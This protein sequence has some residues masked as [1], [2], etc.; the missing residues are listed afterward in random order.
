[1]DE[2]E[3]AGARG[4]S[5][6]DRVIRATLAMG[7]KFR[8]RRV[9]PAGDRLLADLC[10]P[11]CRGLMNENNLGEWAWR[12][13]HAQSRPP[14]LCHFPKTPKSGL[15]RPRGDESSYLIRC[16]RIVSRDKQAKS[17]RK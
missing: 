5:R 11:L 17:S 12:G 3:G 4:S 1:M 6:D 10:W 15:H 9:K 16:T 2:P 13:M 14:H 7:G 8:W